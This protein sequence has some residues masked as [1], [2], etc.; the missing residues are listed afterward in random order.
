MPLHSGMAG[1]GKTTLL[2]R[3]NT[4]LR[5]KGRPGYLLNLDPAVADTPYEPN[6]DIRDT[7]RSTSGTSW[8]AALR[9]LAVCSRTCSATESRASSRG[10]AA[11]QIQAGHAAVWAWP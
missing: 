9:H 11:G 7:V 6:I 1:S 3:I 4:Y 8:S 5:E 10:C 2:Q